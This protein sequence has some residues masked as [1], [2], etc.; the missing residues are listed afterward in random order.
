MPNAKQRIKHLR[1]A[2][3]DKNNPPPRCYD[4][5]PDGT[6]GNMKLSVGCSYCAY[7]NDCWSDANDGQGLRKFIYSK[8]PRWLTKVVNEPNVSED[9]P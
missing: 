1:Q 3:K 5:E 6:S 9:I 4:E 8:G 7:K 2:L